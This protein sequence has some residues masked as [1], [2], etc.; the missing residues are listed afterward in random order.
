[1]ITIITNLSADRWEEYQKLRIKAVTDVPQ[2][3]LATVDEET[4]KPEEVWRKRLQDS[5]DVNGQFLVFAEDDGELI[6]LMGAF[7]EDNIKV[8]HTATVVSVYVNPLYRGQGISSLLMKGLIDMVS[9]DTKI[10]RLELMVVT[11]QESA[12]ALYKRFGFEMIGT[13]HKEVCVDGVYYD[14]HIMEKML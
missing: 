11:T 4:N 13:V 12:I 2:A 8:Q 14:E 5:L 10:I 3:F 1:M 9:Q 6:G 7:V